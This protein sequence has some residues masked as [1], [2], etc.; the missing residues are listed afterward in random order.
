MLRFIYN[1]K[2]S[3]P[4]SLSDFATYFF[5]PVS[6]HNIYFTCGLEFFGDPF[7]KTFVGLLA[8]CALTALEIAH[9]AFLG[10][11]NGEIFAVIMGLL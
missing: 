7:N 3:A 10:S 11:W 8:M 4:F 6:S 2:N 5:S 1:F 9:L